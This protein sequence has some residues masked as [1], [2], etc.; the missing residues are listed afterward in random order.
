[1][2]GRRNSS[3][4]SSAVVPAPA[5][6]SASAGAGGKG[7]GMWG[8]RFEG[9]A[10]PLFKA[11]NDSLPFDYRLTLQDIR[12]SIAWAG[13][14]RAAGVLTKAEHAQLSAALAGLAREVE[15]EPRLP[16]SSDAED[17]HSWVEGRL[18]NALGP[19]GK[20]LHTGR[21]RNDQVATD[22]RLWTRD[23]IDARRGEIRELRAALVGLAEREAGVVF[24]GYTH[25][26]RA[27]PILFAHWCMA[28]VEMLGRDDERFAGARGRV[29]I[30][31]LGSGALAGTTY[32]IDRAALAK[33]L[34]FDGPSANSL[35]ATSDR[36]FVLETLSAAALTAAHLSR[37]AEDMV[38]Y[39][40][41]EFGL[42]DMHD[43]VSSGSSLMPQKKN[44]DAAELIRGK[45]GRIAGSLVTMLVTLKGLPLAYN[46]DLQEDKEPLFDAMEHLSLCVRMATRVV[47]TVKVRRDAALAAATGGYANATELADYFVSLG[48]P[49]RDAHDMVGRLVRLALG[50]KVP[51]EDLTLTEFREHCAKTDEKVYE[52]LKVEK[53]LK[54]REIVGGTGPRAV[55]GAV[56]RGRSGVGRSGDREIGSREIERSGG[57]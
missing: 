25:V 38:L 50:R 11:F 4:G 3:R 44:P 2:A 16:L 18:V 33:A 14:L 52:W 36:D 10:D 46:K 55:A 53:G 51:L 35:D 15:A 45:C 22:L 7:G 27:Q 26:Q 8:G 6:E 24:P 12:G 57:R 32:P 34:G 19:L 30:C 21:S 49:F 31:P 47:S 43:S 54:R 37:M 29:N 28:Y 42:L 56:K 1:M 13:A 5:G 20:K 41:Q 40:S 9:A 23:E 17:V 39:S 48:V